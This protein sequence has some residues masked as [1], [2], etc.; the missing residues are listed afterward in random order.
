MVSVK[1]DREQLI[2][3][4][5]SVSPVIAPSMLKC[6]FGNLHREFELWRSAG[7]EV[8]HLEVMD[9]PFVPT[10]SYGPRGME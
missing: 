5:R 7:T 4:I 3:Q 2:S 1:R 6:D 8:M 9:G 10:R